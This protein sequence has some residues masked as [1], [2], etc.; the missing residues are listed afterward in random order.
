MSDDAQLKKA[1]KG[2]KKDKKTDETNED[3]VFGTNNVDQQLEMVN[4]GGGESNL[5]EG[6]GEQ[7]R[8]PNVIH[9]HYQ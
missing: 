5:E 3:V 7:R 1:K 9:L 8:E 2:L 6:F 4:F